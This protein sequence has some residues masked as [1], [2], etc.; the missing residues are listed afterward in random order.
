MYLL[1]DFVNNITEG[2][3]PGIHLD[4]SD[5]H[6]YFVHYFDASISNTSCL[7]SEKREE[8]NATKPSNKKVKLAQS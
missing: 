1:S 6:N 5:T 4:H 2:V 8:F 3:L 7:E